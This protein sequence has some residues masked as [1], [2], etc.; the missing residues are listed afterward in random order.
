MTSNDLIG[1]RF[2]VKHRKI[3]KNYQKLI[4]YEICTIKTHLCV[5]RLLCLLLKSL[6]LLQPGL[7]LAKKSSRKLVKRLM[8]EVGAPGLVVAVSIDGATVWSKGTL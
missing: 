6:S 3:V 4:F 1:A 7:K 5:C 2:A 8:E